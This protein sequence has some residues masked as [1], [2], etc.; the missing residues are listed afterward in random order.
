M[1]YI[2]WNA[3]NNSFERLYIVVRELYGYPVKILPIDNL[4]VVQHS[5]LMLMLVFLNGKNRRLRVTS[6]D[7]S[8]T[9]ASYQ[10]N[11]ELALSL[12]SIH[13]NR[14]NYLRIPNTPHI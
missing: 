4:F 8:D 5:Y 1:S 3:L 9:A 2:W 14:L 13:G 10:L 11:D 12:E 6:D 7:W